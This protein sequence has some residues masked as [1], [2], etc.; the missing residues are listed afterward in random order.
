LMQ[1]FEYEHAEFFYYTPRGLDKEGQI[2]PVRGGRSIAKPNYRVGPKRIDCYSLHLVQEGEV[3]FEFQGKQVR[4]GTNDLFC[5]FPG[6][7]YYYRVAAPE[8]PLR[9]CWIVMDGP[10]ANALLELAGLTPEAPYKHQYNHLIIEEIMDR[11]HSLMQNAANWKPGVTL[12]LQ[13][14]LFGFFAQI[15]PDIVSKPEE[16]PVSWIQE[17]IHF[18]ELHASE[19]VSVQQV[20]SY[21]GVHR[22]YFSSVFT[23][24][25]G[26]SP[27]SYLQ[28]IRMEKA[29]QLLRETDATVT[30]IAL[31]LGYPNLFSFTRAFKN[32]YSIPP[33]RLRSRQ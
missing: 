20:A 33:I 6:S 11:V 22:S 5:L 7:T 23:R 26:S 1:E 8:S 21:A 4:L 32:Y 24:E 25:V 13:S 28:K 15:T 9:L 31:S 3:W 10:R 12:E 19:G 29:K 30:E 2:W 17:C 27:L 16:E 14:L 18:M